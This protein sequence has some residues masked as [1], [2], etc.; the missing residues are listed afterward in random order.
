MP[1]NVFIV[2]DPLSGDLVADP[3]TVQ[4]FT[5]DQ[6]ICWKIL[7]DG[8]S[9]SRTHPGGPIQFYPGW[10]GSPPAPIGEDPPVGEPDLRIYQCD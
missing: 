1:Q 10:M 9:W 6:Q 7:A 2:Q 5:N 8:V 3:Y 4:I